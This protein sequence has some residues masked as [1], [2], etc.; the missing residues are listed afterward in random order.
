[1]LWPDR[2]GSRCMREVRPVPR[3][4]RPFRQERRRVE[5]FALRARPARAAS[6]EVA[7]RAPEGPEAPRAQVLQ[8]D[9]IS[10]LF[11]SEPG[12]TMP[13]PPSPGAG[14]PRVYLLDCP[15][16]AGAMARRA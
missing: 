5:W 4:L 11:S 8:S 13:S 14:L 15:I 7:A 3:V 2:R 6:R 10:S 1:M 16:L 9:E 12:E